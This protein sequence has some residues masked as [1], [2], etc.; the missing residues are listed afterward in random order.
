MLFETADNP[1]REHTECSFH[2]IYQTVYLLITELIKAYIFKSVSCVLS[3][4]KVCAWQSPSVFLYWYLE[5]LFNSEYEIPL[6]DTS[7]FSD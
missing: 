6:Y 7:M 2:V 3:W 5:S 4:F 1:V